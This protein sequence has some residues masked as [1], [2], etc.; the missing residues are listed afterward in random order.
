MSTRIC[1]YAPGVNGNPQV[2]LRSLIGLGSLL[3]DN[4][5]CIRLLAASMTSGYGVYDKKSGIQL[6]RSVLAVFSLS[7][8]RLPE[9]YPLRKMC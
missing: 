5:T 6:D 7:V 3:M 8:Q 1:M 9:V 4:L 2:R